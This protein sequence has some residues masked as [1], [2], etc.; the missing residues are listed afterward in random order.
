MYFNSFFALTS[1]V[2]LLKSFY[3]LYIVTDRDSNY[4]YQVLNQTYDEQF[5]IACYDFELD[6]NNYEKLIETKKIAYFSKSKV[7]KL[8]INH[9]FLVTQNF[10]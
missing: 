2:N 3:V 8:V 5:L 6:P 7:A 4:I 10:W 1:F 9:E